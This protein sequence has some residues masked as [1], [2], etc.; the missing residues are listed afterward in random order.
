MC[1]HSSPDYCQPA[2]DSDIPGPMCVGGGWGDSLL[3]GPDSAKTDTGTFRDCQHEYEAWD[4][5]D[6]SESNV[7]IKS[8]SPRR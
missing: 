1:C 3:Q 7:S 8:F 5:D 2:T 6:I 4:R